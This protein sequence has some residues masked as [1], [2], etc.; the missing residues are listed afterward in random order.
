[1]DPLWVSVFVT[2]VLVLITGWYAWQVR[3]QTDFLKI[4]RLVKEMDKLVAP[5]YSKIGDNNI[6]LKGSPGY[7]VSSSV[8][9]QEYFK[10]WDEVKRNKYL[11]P[12]Y[13]RLA[14]DNCLKNKNDKVG[15]R[16]QDTAYV[17]AESE[18]FEAIKRR[19]SELEKELSTFA[20]RL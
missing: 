9:D 7:R 20:K 16:T 12:D 3:K 11:A 19:Y 14:I 17:Q 2:S 15:D 5:L 18:L 13:L 6:F 1:M 10:F 4:D 8:V